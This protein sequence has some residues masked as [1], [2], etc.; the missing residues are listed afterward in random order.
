MVHAQVIAA[1]ICNAMNWILAS[2]SP[3]RKELLSSLGIAFQCVNA[4]VEESN[5]AFHPQPETIAQNNAQKKAE[6]VANLYPQAHIIGA[7]TIVTLE[8]KIFYKPNTIL[9]AKQ[10]LK[11]LSGKQHRV[12]TAVSVVCKSEKFLKNF[13]D[14]TLVYFKPLSNNFIDEYFQFVHPLDKSG[15]YAIQAPL[16][17]TFACISGSESNVVGFP[18]EKFSELVLKN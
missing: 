2:S 8:G 18:V 13:F 14:Q 1:V 16:T 12:I 5:V 15:A 9:E 4:D 10:M 3:R 17:Q 11:Q 6:Y 7:D